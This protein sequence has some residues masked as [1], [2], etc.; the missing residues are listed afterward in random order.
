MFIAGEPAV[1][2]GKGD[3]GWRELLRA[4]GLAGVDTLSLR[5][6]VSSFRRRSNWFDLDNLVVPVLSAVGAR[7]LQSVWA[8]VETGGIPGVHLGHD[9]PPPAPEAR[10][11]SALRTP[12]VGSVHSAAPLAE[13]AEAVVLGTDEPLGCEIVLGPA[14]G[15]F[16][17]GE[18]RGPAKPIIDS[19][20]PLV[21]GTAGKQADHR[22]RDLRVHPDVGCT[23]ATVALWLL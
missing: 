15:P 16:V 7:T 23:G 2:W 8:T 21:G 19:L 4:S 17:W 14:V 10:L 13:F 12:P 18:F 9:V 20:W 3:Q 22:I 11:R 5:F 6:V 1:F